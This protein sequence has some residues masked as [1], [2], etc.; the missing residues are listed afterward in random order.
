MASMRRL[1][2]TGSSPLARGTQRR[3][4]RRVRHGRFIP[5]RAGNTNPA[6]S[7]A[8]PAPVHPR[9]RGE[10]RRLNA[11]VPSS[12]GS[13]PLA[14]G[15]PHRHGRRCDG[16]RF[17]PARAG[18][19][20]HRRRARSLDT[21]HPRSR[22]EHVATGDTAQAGDGSSPLARG[23]HRGRRSARPGE[24]FIP[25]RAGNTST[26]GRAPP[27]TTVHPRSRG[28]HEGHRRGIPVRSGSSPLARG[29]RLPRAHERPSPRFI[30][31]RAG[32][33][34]RRSRP[35][36]PTAVHPRSRGEHVFQGMSSD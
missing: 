18:N 29:T 33:T 12:I 23:T 24:R 22:G 10:H 16:A 30:P 32:N 8:V 1:H 35:P 7:A 25:A 34:S 4:A 20:S 6:V 15:T 2:P 36:S 19:T 31:A 21:V 14:R 28:E 26:S 5:A 9:S 27:S 17:I 3:G 13:S 11:G